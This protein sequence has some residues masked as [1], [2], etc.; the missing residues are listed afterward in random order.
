MK[1]KFPPPFFAI[2]IGALILGFVILITTSE[3]TVVTDEPTTTNNTVTPSTPK[4]DN[5]STQ[6]DND[7][8]SEEYP[9][10]EKEELLVEDDDNDEEINNIIEYNDLFKELEKLKACSK[11][12]SDCNLPQSDPRIAELELGQRIAKTIDSI[13]LIS[14][15]STE[16]IS[17]YHEVAQEFVKHPDGHVQEAALE[18]MATLQPNPDNVTALLDGLSNTHDAAI[19]RMSIM[20][21]SRHDDPQL[22]TQID[23]LL[24]NTLKTGGHFAAQE[25]AKDILPLLTKDNV[26][27]YRKVATE[28]PANSA[29]A[30][31]LKANLEEFDMQRSGG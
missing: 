23:T 30:K 13:T 19:Y 29:K 28:L 31:A 2:I 18:L 24:I 1:N 20:E 7:V 26:E 15:A 8:D 3:T 6:D 25:V 5:T 21:F 9:N 14:Q 16:D 12:I 11:G 10:N 17:Q 22:K 27:Q 4:I